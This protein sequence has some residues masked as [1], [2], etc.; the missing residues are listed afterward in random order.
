MN[1]RDRRR[2]RRQWR[3]QVETAY[4]YDGDNPQAEYDQIWAWLQQNFGTRN[5]RCG[6]RE[7]GYGEIWEFDSAKK[8]AA[9]ALRWSRN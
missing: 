4:I 2:D 9:F 1:S 6:W 5:D 8:A 7:R 3:Y